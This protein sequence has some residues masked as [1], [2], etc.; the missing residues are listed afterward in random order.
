M[1]HRQVAIQTDAAQEAYAN[2]DVLVEQEAAQ[3]TQP[4]P[5]APVVILKR[6]ADEKQGNKSVSLHA[7][8][9]WEPLFPFKSKPQQNGRGTLWTVV[10]F[11][12][13]AR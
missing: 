12:K 3:L 13:S 11:L 10:L 5:M 9:E 8:A 1:D 2:V 6:P 7:D 4:L